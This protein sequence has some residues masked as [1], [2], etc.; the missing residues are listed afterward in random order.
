VIAKAGEQVEESFSCLCGHSPA[1]FYDGIIDLINS[2]EC[3][4]IIDTSRPSLVRYVMRPLVAPNSQRRYFLGKESLKVFFSPQSRV[5]K[6]QVVNSV[7]NIDEGTES[8]LDRSPARTFL[9][10]VSLFQTLL[11]HLVEVSHQPG[12]SDR[13]K[14]PRL[15]RNEA[16]MSNTRQHR[17]QVN[18]AIIEALESQ[19]VLGR[20]DHGFPRNILSRRRYEGIEAVLL[21]LAC[22][23][24]GFTSC[25]WGTRAEWDALDG[26]IREGTGTEIVG[27]R[28]NLFESLH[29]SIVYNL[30][31]IS[32]DFPVS[33]NERPTF[34]YAL[35][36]RVITNT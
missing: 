36:E 33:R 18:E 30:C 29:P 15:H 26:T 11:H 2:V 17:E 7:T 31:Q 6:P 1:E 14:E 13:T 21:L 25:W 34:D 28:R 10:S 27:G 20:S 16:T 23:R 24:R 4:R 8:G 22:Q 19:M 32:G 12:T 5:G 35:V 9:H 3:V